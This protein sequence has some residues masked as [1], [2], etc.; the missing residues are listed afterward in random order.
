MNKKFSF[1]LA[2]T[3]FTVYSNAQQKPT[4]TALQRKLQEQNYGRPFH[5]L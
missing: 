4:G 2:A 3:S 5:L 1:L